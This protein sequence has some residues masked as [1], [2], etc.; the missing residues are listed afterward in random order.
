MNSPMI[1]TAIAKKIANISNPEKKRDTLVDL[2]G[3]TEDKLIQSLYKKYRE[4][5]SETVREKL[6][7]KMT[8]L[9]LGEEPEPVTPQDSVDKKLTKFVPE[10]CKS[11]YEQDTLKYLF[12][13]NPDLINPLPKTKVPKPFTPIDERYKKSTLKYVYDE[14]PD[15]AAKSLTD[16]NILITGLIQSGKTNNLLAIILIKKICYNQPSI[17]VLRNSIKDGVQ[18]TNKAKKFADEHVEYMRE[19]GYTNCPSIEVIYAGDMCS[20]MVTY[21]NGTEERVLRKYKKVLDGLTG[22][23]KKLIIAMANGHQLRYINMVM[24]THISPDYGD[25]VLIT[26]EADSIGYSEI[27]SPKQPEFHMSQEYSTLY[28]R[29]CQRIEVTA[30]CMDVM[31]GNKD[32]VNTNIITLRPSLYYKGIRNGIRYTKIPESKADKDT[33]YTHDDPVIKAVYTEIEQCEGFRKGGTFVLS[34]NHPVICLHKTS[35][36]RSDHDAFY[37]YF[38]S[39]P[40]RQSQWVVVVEDGR[41]VKIYGESLKGKSMTLS[42]ETVNDYEETGEFEFKKEAID[43]QEILQWFFDNGGASCYPNI[44]IKSGDLAGRSRSYVSTNGMWHLTHQ[45]YVPA[46]GESVPSM[47]QSCRLCHNRPDSVPLTMYA[48]KQV[49]HDIQRGA[50]M[51]D[52]MLA[53]LRREPNKRLV[54]EEVEK[55][56][57]NRKKVPKA[58]V[59]HSVL[60]KDFKPIKVEGHDGHWSMKNYEKLEKEKTKD[61][62][63]PVEYEDEE[64]VEQDENMDMNMDK[65]TDIVLMF[66][67]YQSVKNAYN[68]VDSKVNLIVRAFINSGFKALSVNEIR[69][70]DSRLTKIN[71]TNYDRWDDSHSAKYQILSKTTTGKYALDKKI[72]DILGLK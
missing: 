4:T 37:E 71:I 44:V 66:K 2:I 29:A 10:K 72:I 27:K 43:I 46:K 59:C 48:P 7:I 39:N 30:T 15:L 55:A 36:L 63:T 52:E 9:W 61:L 69:N 1:A 18:I 40:E 41:G 68:K 47:M 56:L 42:G 26:D 51:Q 64:K 24:D 22:K 70:F 32:L 23:N 5:T 38:K 45:V 58:R 28:E 31:Y 54:F 49:I 60:N 57:W 20:S 6:V 34:N 35:R 25:F 13:V 19:I 67:R 12:G 11:K 65:D 62:S 50:V 3:K 21:Q 33:M 16:K 53:R 17:L 14:Y 8:R